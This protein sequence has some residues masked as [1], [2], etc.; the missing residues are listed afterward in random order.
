MPAD[1][2]V[3]FYCSLFS[4]ALQAMG[5]VT[6]GLYAVFLDQSSFI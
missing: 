1:V 5:W 3:N 2:S 4:R 6:L